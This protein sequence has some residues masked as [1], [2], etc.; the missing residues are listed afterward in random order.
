M[1]TG[2]FTFMREIHY[3]AE[4]DVTGDRQVVMAMRDLEYVKPETRRLR[5]AIKDTGVVI[6]LASGEI[7]EENIRQT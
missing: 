1:L 7:I 5:E 2:I 4:A 6:C 3:I